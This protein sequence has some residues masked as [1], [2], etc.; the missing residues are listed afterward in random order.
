MD[1]MK[2]LMEGR[3]VAVYRGT[4]TTGQKWK[5]GIAPRATVGLSVPLSQP[6]TAADTVTSGD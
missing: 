6:V 4:I 2:E 5:A 1:K 3:R